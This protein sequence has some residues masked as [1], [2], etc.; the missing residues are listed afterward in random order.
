MRA[1]R[2]GLWGERQQWG[3]SCL[4]KR[5]NLS[6]QKTRPSHPKGDP[7][8]PAAFKNGTPVKAAGSRG[9]AP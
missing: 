1:C 4:L 7:A 3:L 2:A 5:L 8:A 6:R 9:G